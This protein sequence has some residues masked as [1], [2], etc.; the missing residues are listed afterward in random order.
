FLEVTSDIDFNAQLKEKNGKMIFVNPAYEGKSA[1][2]KR[3]FRSGREAVLAARS[4]AQE[5][6]KELN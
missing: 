3:A 6:L 5:W 1:D 4:F 2:W